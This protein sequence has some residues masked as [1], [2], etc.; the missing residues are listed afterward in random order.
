MSLP[1]IRKKEPGRRMRPT[2]MLTLAIRSGEIAYH[3]EFVL[4]VKSCNVREKTREHLK[5]I[6]D[7]LSRATMNRTK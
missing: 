1:N 4:F 5:G 3:A 7:C 2:R 6:N